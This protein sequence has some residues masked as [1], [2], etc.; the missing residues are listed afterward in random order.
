MT[1]YMRLLSW[2]SEGEQL[3]SRRKNLQK[4]LS[5][6][7]FNSADIWLMVFGVWR[8]RTLARVT[9]EASIQ[10]FAVLLH[11]R[12]ECLEYLQSLLVCLQLKMP[13]MENQQDRYQSREHPFRLVWTNCNFIYSLWYHN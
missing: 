5:L 2:Y 3:V 11:Q 6:G 13:G 4:K 8:S 10:Y 9:T 1:Y 7:K 12:R